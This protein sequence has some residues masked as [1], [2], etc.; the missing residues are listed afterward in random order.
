MTKI[1]AEVQ[2]ARDAA[3]AQELERVLEGM[4]RVQTQ[5][6]EVTRRHRSAIARADCVEIGACVRTHGELLVAVQELEH[7]RRAVVGQLTSGTKASRTPTL[8]EL[9]ERLAEPWRDRAMG[10]AKQLRETVIRVGEEQRTVRLAT[11][12]LLA[13]MDGLVRQIAKKLSHAGTYSARGVVEAG[14][15]QVASGLDI[16]G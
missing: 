10:L 3:L 2:D 12:S 4:L 15:Q 6:L 11:E 7:R 8:T 1:S 13:H 14:R 16:A 5:L 9:A